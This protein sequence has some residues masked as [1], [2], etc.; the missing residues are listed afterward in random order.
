MIV[1]PAYGFELAGAV[2]IAEHVLSQRG[3]PYLICPG[4][5]AR[6]SAN[7]SMD[8]KEIDGFTRRH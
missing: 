2:Q 4:L 6:F 3:A 8:V 7:S 1:Q 5:S